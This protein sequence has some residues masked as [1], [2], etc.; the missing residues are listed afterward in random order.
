M[1]EYRQNPGVSQLN[2]VVCA[3]NNRSFVDGSTFGTIPE[4]ATSPF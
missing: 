1:A 4:E 2:E 3:E